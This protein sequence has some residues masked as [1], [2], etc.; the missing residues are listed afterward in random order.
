MRKLMEKVLRRWGTD[1]VLQHAEESFSLRGLLYY[2][3]SESWRNMER[4]FSVLG[5]IPGGQYVYIG[6]A[7]PA[8]EVGDT[9]VLGTKAYELRRAEKFYFGNVPLYSWGLCVEKGGVPIW[10]T[11]S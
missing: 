2:S 3:G 5:Q 8:I 7:Q 4:N 9:L 11:H 6:P 10:E 1:M